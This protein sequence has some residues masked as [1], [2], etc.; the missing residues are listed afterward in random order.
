MMACLLSRLPLQYFRRHS[1]L[2]CFFHSS[3][4]STAQL[5]S[6]LPL[7]RNLQDVKAFTSILIV[8]GL[9][10]HQPFTQELIRHCCLQGCAELCLSAFKT[11]HRPSL[12]LQNS[13]LRNLSSNGLFKD[14]AVVYHTCRN[15]GILSDSYTYPFMI[16]ACA[17][18]RDS[19]LGRTVHGVVIRFGFGVNLVVQTA[20][21]DFYSKVGEIWDARQVFDEIPQP[22]VVAWNALISGYSFNGLDYKVLQVFKV[23]C[24]DVKPNAITVASVLPVCSQVNSFGI[25]LHG[26]AYKL[27]YNEEESLIPAMISMYANRGDILAAGDLFATSARKDVAVWNSVIS[28]YTRNDKLENAVAVFRTM[29]IDGVKPNMVTFVSLVPSS[30]NLGSVC[31]VVM[32]HGY[33]VKFGYA[34]EPLVVTALI[35][36]YAKLGDLGSAEFLFRSLELRT[37]LAWNS[38]VS[39]YT[40]H[41]LW[42]QSL[43]A[44]RLMQ[45]DGYTPDAI[46]IISLVSSCSKLNASLP[47][48]SAHGFIIRKGMDSNLVASNALLAFY[49]SVNDLV[50]AFRMLDRM[51]MKNIVSWNTIISGCVANGESEKATLMFHQMREEGIAFDEI[52]LISILP[53]CLKMLG[54]A[55]HSYAIR[56]SLTTDVSLANSLISMYVNQEDLVAARSLF[57]EMYYK[58]VVSWNA[59]LTGY[60]LHN[61]SKDVVE[62]FHQM[63]LED[64]KL[65]YVTLLNLLPACYTLLQGKSIHAYIVRR[66]IPLETPLLTSLMIMYAAF[67][68]SIACLLLFDVGDKSNISLWNTSLSACLLLKTTAMAFSFFSEM[69]CNKIE[70]DDVTILNII[71]ACV[72]LN[73]LHTSNSV[74]SYLVR[75]G[76]DKY[77]TVCN[78]LIDLYAKCGSI[79]CSAKLFD[80]MPVKDAVSWS[81][82]INCYGMHGHIIAVINLYSQMRALGI[83]PDE[84]T[85]MSVLSACSHTGAVEQGMMVFNSMIVEGIR[86]RVEHYACMVD[87]LGR[88][89]HLN[90]AYEIAKNFQGKSGANLLE[91]LLG[92]CL[93]HGNYTVGE[94]IGKLLVEMNPWESGAYVILHNIYA[95][96]GKWGEAG[97]LRQ[98]MILPD[99]PPGISRCAE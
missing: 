47:A 75:K 21:L 74:F 70:P 17:G 98:A 46:S 91:S 95:A 8:H 89:G 34:E 57:D 31:P 67:N 40:G 92:A 72:D 15:S 38:M 14:A 53:S 85:Y 28:A 50:S 87:L 64:Q 1:F 58:S 80:A 27:G 10:K 56:T 37:L 77:V 11:I 16:K 90:E 45:V 26:L 59:V 18:L 73:N 48:K 30:E 88:S 78:A 25:S 68:N 7:C 19:R 81:T 79:S 9:I 33:L 2:P 83:K 86:P 12:S 54:S 82:M 69:V 93:S 63:I 6:L 3:Y 36:S 39:A 42:E 5:T 52:T 71:S 43:D 22:D 13:L 76:F 44:F 55:I 23:M 99:K 49:C 97:N 20:L 32:F 94:E 65:N 62:L 60:R 66:M 35:S 61:F 4:H 96:A 41:G 84:V 29:L 24:N 51:A